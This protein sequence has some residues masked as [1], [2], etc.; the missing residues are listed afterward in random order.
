MSFVVRINVPRDVF[1]SLV[2]VKVPCGVS[3]S[4]VVQFNVPCSVSNSLV[5]LC[6]VSVPC[7]T[8][9]CLVGPRHVAKH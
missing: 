8:L 2:Q 5:V 4:L 6:G 1:S 9:R 3:N 7:R